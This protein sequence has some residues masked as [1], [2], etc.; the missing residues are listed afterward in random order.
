MIPKGLRAGEIRSFIKKRAIVLDSL[1]FFSFLL[2]S[3][4]ELVSWVSAVSGFALPASAP[5]T[6]VLLWVF[7]ASA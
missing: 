7:P 3:S 5:S 1:G 4:P 2:V 6:E